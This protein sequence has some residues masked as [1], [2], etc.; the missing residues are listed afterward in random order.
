MTTEVELTWEPPEGGTTAGQYI[1]RTDTSTTSFNPTEFT[2]I[3]DVGPDVGSYVDSG[4]DE[5]KE[6]TYAIISYNGP[7]ETPAAIASFRMGFNILVNGEEVSGVGLGDRGST[8]GGGN[9]PELGGVG[10]NG[11]DL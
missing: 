4:L 3:D 1:F 8:S 5:D 6:Y 10:V 9:L 11:V 7:K 2:Q